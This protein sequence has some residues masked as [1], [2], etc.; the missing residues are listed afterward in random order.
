MNPRKEVNMKKFFEGV[1]IGFGICI[2][3]IIIAI[4]IGLLCTAGHPFLA[5]AL[6]MLLVM[7][8]C[9]WAHMG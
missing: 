6:V 1:L 9:G 8:G 2:M 3:S 4:L 5:L 7:I